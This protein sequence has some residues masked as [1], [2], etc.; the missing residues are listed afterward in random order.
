[1]RMSEWMTLLV[2]LKLLLCV[3]MCVTNDREI[4]IYNSRASQSLAT[5][6]GRGS[7]PVW[8]SITGQYARDALAY[9]DG[10]G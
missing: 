5:R 3:D 6:K 9:I 4:M 10:S 7:R 8:Q 1:M 2:L